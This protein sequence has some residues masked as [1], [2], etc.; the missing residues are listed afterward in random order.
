MNNSIIRKLKYSD[1]KNFL[2][3]IN[4]F[5][6]T[7]FS[8]H[9][10]KDTL[11]RIQNNSEIWVIEYNGTLVAS[12]TILYEKKFIHNICVLA[13]VEDICVKKEYRGLGYGKILLKKIIEEAEKKECYKISLNCI[14]DNIK[15]YEKCGFKKNGNQMT[16]ETP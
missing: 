12:G 1:Y 13:H 5:R 14:D 15:F 16:I 8:Y 6:T 4:D 3:L 2:T 10:F 9:T 11:E 7:S